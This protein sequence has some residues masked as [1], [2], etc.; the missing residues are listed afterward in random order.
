MQ[1]ILEH[2]LPERRKYK[3]VIAWSRDFGIGQYVSL[4]LTNEELTFDI[5]WE[6]FEEFRRP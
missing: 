5:M 4:N 3:K 6:N 1:N 2:E